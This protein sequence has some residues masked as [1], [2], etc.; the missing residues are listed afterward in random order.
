MNRHTTTVKIS[1]NGASFERDLDDFL[2]SASLFDSVVTEANDADTIIDDNDG[3]PYTVDDCTVEDI[4]LVDD[5]YNIDLDEAIE[6]ANALYKFSDDEA[7]ACLAWMQYQGRMNYIGLFEAKNDFLAIYRDVKSY[8]QEQFDSNL[9]P[10]AI[11]NNIDWEGVGN[12]LLNDNVV[13]DVSSGIAVFS[14]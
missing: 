9:F 6:I 2:D 14:N 12:D 4:Y 7:E 8:A 10:D 3:Q 5:T 13:L 11:A 1:V